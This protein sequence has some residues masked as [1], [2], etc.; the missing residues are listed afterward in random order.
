MQTGFI[1]GMISPHDI[2]E[3]AV[4]CQPGKPVKVFHEFLE[5][6]KKDQTNALQISCNLKLLLRVCKCIMSI[7]DDTARLAVQ[8]YLGVLLD[9]NFDFKNSYEWQELKTV[10]CYCTF[11]K[12]TQSLKE[13]KRK[14]KSAQ[15]N[16]CLNKYI[17][18]DAVSASRKRY[19]L[20]TAAVTPVQHSVSLSP[21]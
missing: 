15:L 10:L 6:S 16:T 9:K 20:A 21:L 18:T 3:V 4:L 11:M 1:D 8:Y 19:L 7:K 14:F 17:H 5:L 2:K 12:N 13:F